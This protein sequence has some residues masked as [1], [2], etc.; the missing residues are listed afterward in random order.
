MIGQFCVFLVLGVRGSYNFQADA[1]VVQSKDIKCR[2][3][4]RP[5]VD[6]C[7]FCQQPAWGHSREFEITTRTVNRNGMTQSTTGDL[8][9]EEDET[10][11][12]EVVLHGRKKRKVAFMPS[13]GTFKSD[14]RPHANFILIT[15]KTRLTPS[16]TMVIGFA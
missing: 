3:A 6:V 12:G 2:Y 11:Q 13:L 8:E 4:L 7:T 5:S 10:E 15:L 16:T 1:L 14:R 9:E